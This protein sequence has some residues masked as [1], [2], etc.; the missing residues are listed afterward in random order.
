MGTH[1]A[2]IPIAVTSTQR[3]ASASPTRYTVM[4]H[5]KK[6]SRSVAHKSHALQPLK[7]LKKSM[8]KA[9]QKKSAPLLRHKPHRILI[10]LEQEKAFR[11]MW[12]SALLFCIVFLSGMW[13]IEVS[14]IPFLSTTFT[15]SLD[16]FIATL[17]F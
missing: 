4:R 2:H 5:T 1:T 16:T 17:P 15:A 8:G 14:A 3:T 11:F 6:V 12:A 9:R 13:L 7:K 10:A